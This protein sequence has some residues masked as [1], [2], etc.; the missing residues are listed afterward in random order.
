MGCI[1]FLGRHRRCLRC[2][3]GCHRLFD[4]FFSCQAVV[5]TRQELHQSLS[6]GI[7]HTC[8]LQYRQQFRCLLEHFITMIQDFLSECLKIHIHLGKLHCLFRD[9]L[10]HSQD[11]TFLRLHNCLICSLYRTYK[12]IGKHRYR[13]LLLALDL[14]AETTQKL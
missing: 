12:S 14:F 5:C 13:N 8:F 3:T 1:D 2:T 9:A 11:R 10:C 6:A 7:Y 4:L